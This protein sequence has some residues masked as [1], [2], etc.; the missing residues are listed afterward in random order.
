MTS[1]LFFYAPRGLPDDVQFFGKRQVFTRQAHPIKPVGQVAN[2]LGDLM[3]SRRVSVF[4][5]YI[6][7]MN[8]LVCNVL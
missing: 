7:R 5:K 1:S 6:Y 3:L 2:I 4:K 8:S